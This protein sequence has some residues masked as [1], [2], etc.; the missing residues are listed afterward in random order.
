VVSNALK[1]QVEALGVK[2]PIFVL[3][4]FVDVVPF[5]AL[6][7]RP[8]VQ[9]TILWVGRFEPEKDPISALGILQDV[10][11]RGVEAKLV[12]LG[13]GSLESTLRRRAAGLPVEF[14]GWQDP[15]ALLEISDVVL[16]TSKHE[17]WG[18]SIVEALAAGVPVVA[19]DVGVAKE[20]GAVVAPRS[21][22]STAV[23]RVLNSSERGVLKIPTGTAGEWA[24]RWK[25]T[26]I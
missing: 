23:I 11:A 18:A 16:C 4:I 5:K 10:R 2:A 19:P 20:A 25:E 26:L 24:A 6:V 12:M 21:E 9:L 1:E 3:P 7:A 15:K 8:H 14:P 22:L 13:A 17:S